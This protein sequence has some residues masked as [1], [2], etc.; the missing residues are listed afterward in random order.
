MSK[1][2]TIDKQAE[3]EFLRIYEVDPDLCKCGHSH[4][5]HHG[6][7]G[8]FCLVSGCECREF[9]GVIKHGC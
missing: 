1:P 4:F 6:E 7:C 5:N 3:D 9:E 2:F 8:G